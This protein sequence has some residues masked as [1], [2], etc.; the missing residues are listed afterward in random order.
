VV[1]T[2]VDIAS[3]GWSAYDLWKN[4]SLKN[5]GYLLWDVAATVLPFVPG[6]WTA[7][8]I[9]AGS[10]LLSKAD[11]FVKTGVWA[12]KAFDRGMDIEKALGGMCNNFPVIDK[13]TKN[14]KGIA[15]SITSIKSMDVTA[16]TYNKGNGMYNVLKGY[17]DDL[18]GF[19]GKEW[20]G[21]KVITDGN[22]K[23]SLELALPP[24]ELSKSQAEQLAKITDYAKQKGIDIIVKIVK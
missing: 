11:D 23:K 22:T 2:V 13:F 20:G 10:K 8:G 9:K 7:K 19:N 5:L 4:P 1:E 12:K 17:V 6:S 14:S 3:I 16:Q 24:V 18:A 15:D 21:I